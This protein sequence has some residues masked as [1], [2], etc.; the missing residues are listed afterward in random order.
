MA[1]KAEVPLFM[2]LGGFRQRIITSVTIGI[3]EDNLVME[4]IDK[5]MRQGIRSIKI[6]GGKDVE[7]DIRIVEIVRKKIGRDIAL[8]F[9]A[10]QGYSL[11]EAAHFIR[12]I[13]MSTATH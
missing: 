2:F 4:R 7:R 12:N 10:N 9:D 6:K 8:T 11:I 3:M 13:K 1:Q 5:L